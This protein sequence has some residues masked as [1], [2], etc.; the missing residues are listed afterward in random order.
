TGLTIA[1]AAVPIARC[2]R[3]LVELE[4]PLG[5][6]GRDQVIGLLIEPIA[7]GDLAG[8]GGAEPLPTVHGGEHA[9]AA[10]GSLR[11]HGF[12]NRYIFYAKLSITGVRGDGERIVSGPHIPSP[13]V[14]DSALGSHHHI[15]RQAIAPA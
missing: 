5:R 9:A 11:A 6:R 1:A 2:R 4:G 14:R 7:V 3:L 10:L 12:G 13:V 8:G 15:R